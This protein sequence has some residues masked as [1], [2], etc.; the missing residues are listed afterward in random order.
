VIN[1]LIRTRPISVKFHIT[2][3]ALN[4][5]PVAMERCEVLQQRVCQ[6]VCPLA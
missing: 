1:L 5:P 4:T 3:T 2:A 6:S